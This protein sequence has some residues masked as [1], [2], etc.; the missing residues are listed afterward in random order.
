MKQ[1]N[2]YVERL[3]REFREHGRILLA[4]DFDSTLKSWHTIQND[5]DIARVIS[6]VKR[7]QEYTYNIIFTSCDPNRYDEIRQH[8]KDIG[9][10]VD[11][12]NQNAIEN[13]PYGHERKP[14]YNCL[15]DD[16]AGL[17]ESLYILES[18]YYQHRGELQGT[19]P[20]SEIG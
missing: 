16:R 9:V 1:E 17:H 7:V 14:L 19:K 12:I 2:K 8:C 10:R 6:L 11:V 20:L 4:I 18:A 5:G 13:L 3:L 15:I